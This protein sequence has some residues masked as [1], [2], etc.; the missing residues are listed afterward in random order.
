MTTN[1]GPLLVVDADDPTTWPQPLADLVYELADDARRKHHDPENYEDLDIDSYEKT[2][3]HVLE[4][5]VVRAWH[6]TRL[7]DHERESIRVQGLRLLTPDLVNE[8]LDQARERGFLTSS[9]HK[10]LRAN[11]HTVPEHRGWAKREDQICL[12]LSTAA[13]VHHGGGGRLLTCWGGEALYALHEGT[14]SELATK[15]R[16]L[17]TATIVTALLDFTTPG[18]GPHHVSRSIVHVL[19]GKALG[20]GPADAGI[21]YRAPVPPHRIES[22]V[23]PGD[24][25]YDRFPG[26]PRR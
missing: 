15:L 20:Y 25:G 3:R 10:T 11:N 8:R 1:P 13:V 5:H 17:G 6:S 19:V 14:A 26:L 18:A 2:V 21:V 24:A 4:G 16:S 9:E 7:L 12:R 23:T 22:I